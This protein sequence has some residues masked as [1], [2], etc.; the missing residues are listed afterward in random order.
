M[1]PRRLPGGKDNLLSHMLKATQ[2]RWAFQPCCFGRSR[3]CDT[4]GR[5]LQCVCC[6]K[7]RQ[8]QREKKRSSSKASLVNRL[9]IAL[10]CGWVGRTPD[11][12]K[13]VLF[14]LFEG[15]TIQR[16]N[17]SAVSC[18]ASDECISLVRLLLFSKALTFLPAGGGFFEGLMSCSE[19]SGS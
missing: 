1:L 16:N 15:R 7:T 19:W 2:P 6:Y 10:L 18:V 11:Q 13:N 9:L 14:I 4:A 5:G 12:L 17:F 3:Q 8:K